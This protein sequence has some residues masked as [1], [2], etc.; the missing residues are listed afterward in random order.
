MSSKA[1]KN[2]TKLNQRIDFVAD[3]EADPTGADDCSAALLA[4][5]TYLQSKSKIG[6]IPNGTYKLSSAVAIAAASNWGMV[7]DNSES[8]QFVYSGANTTNDIL[9]IGSLSANSIKVQLQGFRVTSTTVMTGGIGIHLMRLCRSE[10]I[11]VIPDGQDGLGRL[12]HGIRFNGVDNTYF[13]NYTARAQKDGVQVNGLVGALPKAGLYMDQYKIT[14]CDV[15]LRVGGAFG[16]IAFGS[17]DIAANGDNVVIDQTLVDETNREVF[18]SPTVFLDAA[19][20]CNCVIDNPD[21]SQMWINFPAKVWICSSAS[22]GVWIKNA[23]GA[24]I[25]FD[26][27]VY[28]VGGDGLRVDDP[29]VSI[30]IDSARFNSIPAPG[31]GI[32]FTVPSTAFTMR[33]PVF[34]GV[35]Q[36]FNFTAQPLV[37]TTTAWPLSIQNNRAFFNN[38]FA[39]NLVGGAATVAHGKGGTYYKLIL[40]AFASFKTGS[41][42]WS[43][44]SVTVDAANINLTGGAGTEPYN[45]TLLVSNVANSGW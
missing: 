45:V 20:R 6:Y 3:F 37:V 1:F 11:D 38:D 7:G 8:V 26:A 21:P 17:G 16:G 25:S 10:V 18:F 39:G 42:Q 13:T 12:W 15:G 44:L 27:Y 9:S 33:S 30:A 4:F 40:G 35:D 23:P 28:N 5:A 29:L 36:P 31:Y 34:D 41:N 22:H 19:T 14:L 43:P 24:K 32:N 2:A